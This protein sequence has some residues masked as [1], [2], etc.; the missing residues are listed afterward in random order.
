MYNNKPYTTETFINK[1]KLVHGE[2]YDYS[3]SVYINNITKITIIC[4]EHGEFVQSAVHHFKGMGCKECGKILR[5]SKIRSNIEK[6]ISKS[7]IIH[8]FKYN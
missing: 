2:K 3:K 1:A 6:F 4:S 8:N 7:N 5:F